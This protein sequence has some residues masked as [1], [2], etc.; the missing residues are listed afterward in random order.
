[1]NKVNFFSEMISEGQLKTPSLR[2]ENDVTYH[3]FSQRHPSNSIKIRTSTSHLLI[4]T[5]FDPSKDTL[6]II[7]GWKSD[8][9]SSINYKIRESILTE[10]DLNVFVV[11]WSPI[12]GKSYLSAK[13]AVVRVGVYIADFV[14]ELKE[15]YGV[16][17]KK[18]KF[19]GHSL[20]AHIAGNAGKL[21]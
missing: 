3:F 12:A 9:E 11:D 10:N 19:V 20:G 7:H 15:G 18:I 4:L 13:G 16:D 14:T 21:I 2:S 17:V 5:D 6:F 8:N 1:M